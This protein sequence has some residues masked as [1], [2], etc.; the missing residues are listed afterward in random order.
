MFKAFGA[1]QA[2]QRGGGSFVNYEPL[3][4]LLRRN[5]PDGQSRAI[6][7]LSLSIESFPKALTQLRPKKAT[8]IFSQARTSK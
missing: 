4:N 6:L 1:S 8:N 2:A 7:R 3:R 5:T